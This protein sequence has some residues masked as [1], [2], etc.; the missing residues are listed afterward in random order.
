MDRR[1]L[2][3]APVLARSLLVLDEGVIIIVP[4]GESGAPLLRWVGARA[5]RWLLGW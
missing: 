1:E 3:L 4:R 2:S 5:T